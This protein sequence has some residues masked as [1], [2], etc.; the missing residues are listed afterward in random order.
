MSIP[1][2][3]ASEKSKA[4]HDTLL[5]CGQP[6]ADAPDEIAL[7]GHSLRELDGRVRNLEDADDCLKNIREIQRLLARANIL[8]AGLIES[9]PRG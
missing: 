1:S 5:V 3:D 9:L 4:V 7:L 8:L 2:K 6:E